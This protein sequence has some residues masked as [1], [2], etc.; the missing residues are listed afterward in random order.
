MWELVFFALAVVFLERQIRGLGAAP[1]ATLARRRATPRLVQMEQ[2]AQRL[3]DE[4]KYLAA[5]KAYLSIL[6]LDHKNLSAY[7]Q[8][9]IIYSAQKNY[10]DA[11][12]CFELATRI[13]PSGNTYQNLGLAY[14]ENHNYIKAIAAF[15]KA[16]MFEPSAQRYIGL[17]KSLDKLHNAGRAIT[18][19]EQAVE[20]DP[21]ARNMAT[22]ATLLTSHGKIEQAAE[23]R[24][25]IGADAPGRARV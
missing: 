21:S 24:S 20:L 1:T 2:Y 12:E 6:K 4:K 18:A 9:G 10:V 17:S 25:R 3:Y 23:L 13:T 14:Y 11:I 16:I 15:E 8:L 7:S 5:E 19:L 22:L